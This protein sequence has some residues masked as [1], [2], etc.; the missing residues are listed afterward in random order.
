MCTLTMVHIARLLLQWIFGQL[1]K[2]V[3]ILWACTRKTSRRPAPR[4]PLWMRRKTK[5]SINTRCCQEEL[6][7][8]FS[9]QP[10]LSMIEGF[11]SVV[12]NIYTIEAFFKYPLP[13][14][15]KENC[16]LNSNLCS[17][18]YL[19]KIKPYNTS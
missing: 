4:S 12:S 19:Y 16:D 2:G 15:I 9:V 6:R 1:P 10:N 17:S 8:L 5:G 3:G 18:L 13:P 11:E 7:V 14:M